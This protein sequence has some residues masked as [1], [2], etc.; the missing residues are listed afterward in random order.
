MI[1]EEEARRA[2]G[3]R[4]EA[5]TARHERGLDLDP[6]ECRDQR[7]TLQTFFQSPGRVVGIPGHHNEKKRGVEA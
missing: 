5:E 7:A 1:R 6:G 4:G 2:R 3:L